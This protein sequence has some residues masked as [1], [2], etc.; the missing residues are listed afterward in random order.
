VRVREP[1]DP[2]L[3]IAEITDRTT[4]GGG[5]ALLFENVRGSRLPVAINVYG[6]EQRMAWALGAESIDEVVERIEDL[7]RTAPPDSFA[8]KRRML[9]KLKQMADWMPRGVKN[10]PCQ[11]ET[12]EPA[13]LAHLPI[14]TCWPQDGGPF[15]TLGAVITK[16]PESGLRNVGLYRMQKY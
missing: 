15:I 4:K 3:E 13:S 11:D 7:I 1:V 16:H 5:P 9:P 2:Y 14:L 8:D 6:S 10:A 12:V